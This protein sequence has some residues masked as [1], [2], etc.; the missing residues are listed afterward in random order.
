VPQGDD[1]MI[2][3]ATDYWYLC[4]TALLI[5]IATAA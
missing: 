3:W 2:T 4:L 5:G 1:N